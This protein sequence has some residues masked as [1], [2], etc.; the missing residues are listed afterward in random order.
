MDRTP[1]FGTGYDS[2]GLEPAV[3]AKCL[4][5]D[6]RGMRRATVGNYEFFCRTRWV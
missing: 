3:E 2:V 6:H 5:E 4:R 1:G